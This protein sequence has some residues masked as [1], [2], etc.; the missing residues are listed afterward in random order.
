MRFALSNG[1]QSW[2]LTSLI[3][4]VSRAEGEEMGIQISAAAGREQQKRSPTKAQLG[5]TT[6]S[7]LIHRQPTKTSPTDRQHTPNLSRRLVLKGSAV[8]VLTA[9]MGPIMVSKDAYAK[10]NQ[11][12]AAY[13]TTPKD[14]QTCGN[15]GHYKPDN[16]TCKIVE[17]EGIE[18]NHWCKFWREKSS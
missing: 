11:K 5:G 18:A 6:M 4:R 10:M 15:C 8:V 12:A 16:K 7:K 3:G 1:S 2:A 17:G 13:Q 9:A 14:D